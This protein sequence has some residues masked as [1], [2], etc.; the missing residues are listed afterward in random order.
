MDD[1]QVADEEQ[2]TDDGRQKQCQDNEF[3]GKPTDHR[4]DVGVEVFR[5]ERGEFEENICR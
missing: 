5:M 1:V 3:R 4:A 2:I